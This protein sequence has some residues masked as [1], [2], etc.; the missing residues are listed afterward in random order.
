MIAEE[1]GR[2]GGEAPQ[3]GLLLDG[4]SDVADPRELLAAAK[5]VLFDFDGPVCDLFTDPTA[6]E[7]AGRLQEWLSKR[8]GVVIPGAVRFAADPLGYVASVKRHHPDS[9]MAK[10]LERR[11]TLEEERAAELALPTSGAKELIRELSESRI[12]L[13]IATNN[14]AAAVRRY[15]ER[16]DLAES[17][18]AHVHGRRPDV[19]GLKPDPDC[20]SRALTSTGSSPAESVMLGDSVSDLK[21]ADA[22]GVPF[23][24]YAA[25]KDRQDEF[26]SH[27]PVPTV[28][29]LT[30][31]SCRWRG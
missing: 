11:L 27:G 28:D 3:F 26:R 8:F 22:L 14:S 19:A 23:I 29:R 15:L 18:G 5:C 12:R 9:G 16:E 2:M 10:E 20:L 6:S 30:K 13:G 17:F 31:L 24:A 25:N 7:V 4:R 21:A 1:P